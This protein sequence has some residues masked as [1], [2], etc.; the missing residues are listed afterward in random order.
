MSQLGGPGQARTDLP[1][2][3]LPS[4][5]D[6][7]QIDHLSSPAAKLKKNKHNFLTLNI[8]NYKPFPR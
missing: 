7:L 4:S 3:L 1:A 6:L 5:L 8:L 2:G